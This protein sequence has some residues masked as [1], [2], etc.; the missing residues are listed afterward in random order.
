M[1]PRS[2][3]SALFGL[4]L[5]LVGPMAPANADPDDEGGTAELREQLDKASR[6]F[7]DAQAALKRSQ[8]KQQE[9]E[10]E[11]RTIEQEL[12]THVETV[13]EIGRSAYR[14]GRLGPMSALINADS[15]DALP[16]AGQRAR[17]GG[18]QR[19]ARDRQPGADEGEGRAAPR[20]RSTR[21]YASSS[22][23]WR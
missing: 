13:A 3:P 9:Q 11:L 22:A 17:H 19:A 10:T 12:V 7:L 18:R 23:R 1:D 2:P 5:G 8:G 16:G 20:P 4:V 21:R 6:G 14:T 15:P